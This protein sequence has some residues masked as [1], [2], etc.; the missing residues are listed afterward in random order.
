MMLQDIIG[1]NGQW[2]CSVLHD[3]AGLLASVSSACTWH[4]PPHN[5]AQGSG[6]VGNFSVTLAIIDFSDGSPAAPSSSGSAVGPAAGSGGS[7]R[8]ARADLVSLHH[9]LMSARSIVMSVYCR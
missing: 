3:V 9:H 5:E 1:Y 2:C 8:V 7:C 6:T 4:G